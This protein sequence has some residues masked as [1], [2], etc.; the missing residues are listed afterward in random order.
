MLRRSTHLEGLFDV[1]VESPD[2]VRMFK[3]CLN[4]I[5]AGISNFY[6]DEKDSDNHNGN[7]KLS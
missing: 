2:K 5:Y 4:G 6:Y 1:F 3:Y 7:N